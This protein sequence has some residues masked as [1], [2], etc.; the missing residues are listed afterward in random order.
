[1][2]ASILAS[3]SESTELVASSSTRM[4]GSNASARA[5]LTS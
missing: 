2:A 5:K 3:I 4:S 1:V